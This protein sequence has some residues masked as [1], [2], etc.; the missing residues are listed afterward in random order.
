LSIKP[1]KEKRAVMQHAFIRPSLL[2]IKTKRLITTKWPIS[3]I[4]RNDIGTHE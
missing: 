3:L 1:L 4:I 2:Y